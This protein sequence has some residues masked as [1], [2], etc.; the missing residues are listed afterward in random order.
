[1]THRRVLILIDSIESDYQIDAISGVLRATRASNVNLAIVTGG[2]LG[3]RQHPA[4]RNF[5]YDFIPEASVD[6]IVV[7]AGSVSNHC[8]IEHFRAWLQKF[9]VPVVCMGIEVPGFTSVFV[10]NG[11]GTYAAIS[12]LIEGHGRRRIACLRGP[13][14]SSEA[15]QRHDAYARALR[16]HDLS[17]NAALTCTAPIF[18]R[19]DGLAAIETL[20]E[21]RGLTLSNIDAIACVNDDVALGAMEALTRRG[22][23]IPEQISI[24][25]FDDSA[26]ARAANPPL[27]TVNQRVELQGYTAGQALIEMLESGVPA[28]SQRLDSVEVLRASCGCL[29]PHQNDSHRIEIG[30]GGRSFALAF[31]DRQVKLEA[32]MARAAAGR[33]GKQS[34][35]EG[36]ILMALA[37]EL[38]TGDGSFLPAFEGVVRKA[39]SVGGGVDACNDVLTSLRLQ[40]LAIAVS[41]PELRSRV[42]DMF[43]EARLM[44][45]N[46]GLSAY[47]DRDQAATD[48]MRNISKACMG[49]FAAQDTTALS[50][51]L[52]THLPPLGVTACSISRLSTTSARGPR[53]EIVARLS[54]DFVPAKNPALPT[55]SLGID[56]T[57][58][59]RAAVVLMPLEFN[60]RPVGVAGFA[61][62]AHNPMTYELLRE[63]LSVAVYASDVQNAKTAE[64]VEPAEGAA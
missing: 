53:L 22:I 42:E 37:S 25:G 60:R 16:A 31:L 18:A 26:S 10:D 49:A 57:L 34:G 64:P 19:E 9:Q 48:H 12:H 56:Q 17:V 21:K 50:R 14:G 59:H 35:W 63:W 2:W 62:G 44:V 58:Q 36:K 55:G 51:A 45:T 4:P 39:I 27:T 33:L 7:M 41:K 1:M 28:P 46:V 52:S 15:D 61:W 11:I 24:V 5:I 43:Q 30:G 29:I 40:V 8:G 54:P 38:Q 6:G 13:I 3:T 23:L 20:F 32:E 47:R